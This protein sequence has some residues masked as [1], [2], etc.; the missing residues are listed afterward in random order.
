[1]STDSKHKSSCDRQSKLVQLRAD[2]AL[3]IDGS[4]LSEGLR[5]HT[6]NHK[7]CQVADIIQTILDMN[8]EEIETIRW[9]L[10]AILNDDKENRS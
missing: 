5:K 10:N 1:M 9:F 3:G 7:G 8:K 2:V 6:E 4:V